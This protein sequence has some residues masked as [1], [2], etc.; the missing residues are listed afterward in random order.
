MYLGTEATEVLT[1]V[2]RAAGDKLIP[3]KCSGVAVFTHMPKSIE[4]PGGIKQGS[5][6]KGLFKQ[7]YNYL[8]PKTIKT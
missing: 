8:R 1:A 3:T 5:V 6:F 2:S 4:I 7:S